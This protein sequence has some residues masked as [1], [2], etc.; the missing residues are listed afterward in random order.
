MNLLA[1][2]NV[3]DPELEAACRAF[4]VPERVSASWSEVS[5]LGK[6][7]MAS[8]D[9]DGERLAFW[10]YGSGPVILLMHGWSS[11]GSHLMG[12]VKPLLA[13]GFSVA[14]F[15][16]PGHGHSGGE[17]SSVIHAGRAALKLAGHLGDVHGIIAHSA[18]STAALWALGNGLSVQQSVHVCGPS[19]MT[20]VVLGIARAH[21][22][23]DRQ[24]VAFCAWVEAFMG[25]TLASVDLPALALGLRHS[26]L[27]IHDRD[28]RV[29]PVAQ[30]RAL[31]E[32]WARSTLIEKRGPGHRRILGDAQV[33][34]SAVEFMTP[35]GHVL[36][37]LG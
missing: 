36:E 14:V 13:A 19:S 5:F 15:D 10:I 26:G 34:T 29:V 31:R 35:T 16:A 30:S 23:D 22:L 27:I 11:R 24:T 2:L 25:A 32:A 1:D 18:G 7:W 6:G 37:S 3:P 28:D 4:A 9:V 21:C 17:V 12:F 33:I 20:S 8:L